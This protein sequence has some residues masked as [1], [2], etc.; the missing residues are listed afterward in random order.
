VFRA[1]C[2]PPG[3]SS[4][5][6]GTA[7]AERNAPA[8]GLYRSTGEALRLI[9]G[10]NFINVGARELRNR[11]KQPRRCSSA[12]PCARLRAA[13]MMKCSSGL[14]CD[15]SGGGADHPAAAVPNPARGVLSPTWAAVRFE[16]R[17]F[18]PREI[19]RSAGGF[20]VFDRCGGRL[21]MPSPTGR[22]VGV[23]VR[24]S[25][26][27]SDMRGFAVPSSGATRH[28]LP[29]GEGIEL[30]RLQAVHGVRPL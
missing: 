15:S 23:R 10:E 13:W 4:L 6:S 26:D 29:T 14:V 25:C 24:R 8:P 3:A 9:D 5:E 16:H 20:H 22:G 30:C 18:A 1:A 7:A 11:G 27:G 28:L 21:Q 12:A 17:L 2:V 19:P